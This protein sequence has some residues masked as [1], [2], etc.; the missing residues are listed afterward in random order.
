MVG[1]KLL[2]PLLREDGYPGGY[3]PLGERPVKKKD[4]A[5]GRR[6]KVSLIAGKSKNPSQP[7]DRCLHVRDFVAGSKLVNN[8]HAL[9]R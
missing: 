8:G 3:I 2:L 5:M 1:L 4:A 6:W 9:S 7:P